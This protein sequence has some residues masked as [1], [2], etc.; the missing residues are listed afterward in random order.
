MVH[1]DA[2]GAVVFEVGDLQAVGVPDLLGLEGGV[3]AVDLDDRF[4][5]LRLRQR[6]STRKQLS[7]GDEERRLTKPVAQVC[8]WRGTL[9]TRCSFLDIMKDRHRS[10]RAPRRHALAVY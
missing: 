9:I 10:V 3:D 5:L 2:A 7:V 6:R 1:K 4:G 8:H